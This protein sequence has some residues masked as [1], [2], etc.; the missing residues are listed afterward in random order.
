[1]AE[2]NPPSWLRDGCHTAQGDRLIISGLV[3]VEGVKNPS[4]GELAVSDGP[5]GLQVVVAAGHAFIEGDS[6]AGQGMYHVY[7]D[8]NETLTCSAADPTD[9]RIDL[10]VARVYDSQYTGSLDE[11][12][13]EIVTGTPSPSPSA[14]AT[15][16][17][18]IP[19]A[20]VTVAAGDTAL[21][22]GDI[23]DVRTGYQI[24]QEEVFLSVF[25]ASAFTRNPGDDTSLTWDSVAENTGGSSVVSNTRLT[26]PAGLYQLD[27][28]VGYDGTSDANTML[29]VRRNSAGSSSG[30]TLVAQDRRL[31]GTQNS[32]DRTIGGSKAVRMGAGD[33][34]EIFLQ[35]GGGASGSISGITGAGVTYATLVRINK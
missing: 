33:Y 24:C 21:S 2:L 13:L 29:H 15:P 27:Y 32:L 26:V 14:P 18:A 8:A 20:R 6:V 22:S 7:N 35:L 19:L 16:A 25:K 10:V 23:T 30:G 4:S 9:P 28:Q 3:C 1:M 12:R 31:D 17:S 11:W 34:L 5:S